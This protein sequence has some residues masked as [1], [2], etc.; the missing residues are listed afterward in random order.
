LNLLAISISF[1]DTEWD[2][3][4]DGY[5]ELQTRTLLSRAHTYIPTV[6]R[7][8]A[9]I[10]PSLSRAHTH[11]THTLSRAYAFIH[12]YSRTRTRTHTEH[13]HCRALTHSYTH[14]VA[15]A[16]AHTQN[17]HTVARLRTYTPFSVA[18]T[19]T[20]T[21]ARA[22]RHAN[23]HACARTHSLPSHARERTHTQT[24]ISTEEIKSQCHSSSRFTC[25]FFFVVS[26]QILTKGI[27]SHAA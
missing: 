17:T 22:Q 9:L 14:T 1:Q 23:T 12:P 6:A 26:C 5:R 8:H 24:R 27:C 21:V 25:H 3:Q 4:M 7:A 15:R 13:T 19:Y 18:H 20:R 10:D 2:V 16:R 11:R